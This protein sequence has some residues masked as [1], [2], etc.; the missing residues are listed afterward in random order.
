MTLS[1][2]I[3][4]TKMSGAGNDFIFIDNRQGTIAHSV[5][6]SMAAL[7]CKR[8]FSV[9]A[10]G[11]M[12]IERSEKADFSWQFYNA[13]G[14]LAEMCGNGARCAA[15]YAFRQGIAGEKMSF[16]TLAGIIHAE[17][18]GDN[19][20]C[21]QMTSP[22]NPRTDLSVSL[23][24]TDY[25]V[26]FVDTGVPHAVVY[27][28]GLCPI[29][30][31]PIKKWGSLLRHHQLF[32]PRGTNVN[33]ISLAA[34][35]ELIV[36]TYERGVEDETMACGTGAV[37]AALYAA[38]RLGVKSP[39]TVRSSGGEKLKISFEMAE[40][41]EETEPFLTG[42]ARIIYEGELSEEALVPVLI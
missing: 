40:N 23:D 36:R 10:D 34:S 20:V 12:F 39:I 31:V 11:I 8:M 7:V 25:A 32:T 18:C 21:L 28:D 24:G 14:S 17:L 27:V 9:G 41:I 16:E 1:F 4:F 33:F 38:K 3:K 5:Q 29:D 26:D 37:A 2:P 13:D 19:S 30:E 22:E 42:P 15:R 6:S 35:G